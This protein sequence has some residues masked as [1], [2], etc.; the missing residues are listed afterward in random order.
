MSQ[1]FFSVCSPGAVSFCSHGDQTEEAYS[2]TGLETD[3]HIDLRN[4][5]FLLIAVRTP[6]VHRA[7]EYYA[8]FG[9]TWCAQLHQNVIGC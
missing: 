9:R 5:F 2:S 6:H 1:V 7:T 8:L 4:R 3:V